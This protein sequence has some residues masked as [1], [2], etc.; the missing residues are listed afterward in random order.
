MKV[1]ELL[2]SPEKWTQGT[3]AR[4]ALGGRPVPPLDEDAVC[5]CLIGAVRKCYPI[6]SDQCPVLAKITL[7][8][9]TNLKMAVITDWNDYPD[10]TFEQV[11]QLVDKLD[12]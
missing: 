4:D 10:R 2:S 1:K 9:C 12:I 7:E 5:F 6:I 8:L 3:Y 11:K